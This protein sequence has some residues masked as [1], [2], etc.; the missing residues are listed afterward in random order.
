MNKKRMFSLC[1]VRDQKSENGSRALE[2]LWSG[3]SVRA[4]RWRE[5]TA[6]SRNIVSIGLT[7]WIDFSHEQRNNFKS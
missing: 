4:N 6:D 5:G 2:N 7:S 1:E 3:L